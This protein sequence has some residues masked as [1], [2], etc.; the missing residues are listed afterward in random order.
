MISKTVAQTQKFLKLPLETQALYFHLILNADDDGV[1]EAFPV[2]RMIGASDD[3]LGLLVVKR[4]IKALNDEM[5]Y[6]IVDFR[7]QNA[8][9]KDRYTPSKYIDLVSPKVPCLDDGLP[10]GNQMATNGC[11]NISKDNISESN[12]SEFKKDNVEQPAYEF[13]KWLNDV[14][15][16]QVKKGNP[17]NYQFRIPIAYLN[18]KLSKN[19]KF[20]EGNLKPIKAR[21]KDGYSLDDFKKVIDKKYNDWIGNPDMVTYLRPSTLF[22]PKFDGYLNEVAPQKPFN[23]SLYRNDDGAMDNLF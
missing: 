23:A 5:V 22:S 17:E 9:R 3:S 21:F 2:V 10:N 16:E 11:H 20:V 18:Q 19:F 13:P 7:E 1:V 8:I 12:L 14:F 4:F 6:F 15:I